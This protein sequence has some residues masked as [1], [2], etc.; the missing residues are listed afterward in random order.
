MPM[1][2]I[3]DGK[4]IKGPDG[5]VVSN[6]KDEKDLFGIW[7]YPNQDYSGNPITWGIERGLSMETTLII[8]RQMFINLDW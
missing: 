6:F 5:V 8:L 7:K 2:F 1:G 4:T 3:T